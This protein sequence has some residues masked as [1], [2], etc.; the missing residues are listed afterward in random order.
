[1][2][3]RRTTSLM[4]NQRRRSRFAPT[5]ERLEPRHLLAA[6]PVISEIMASNDDNITDEDGDSSDWLKVLNAGD[7][8]IHLRGWYLTDDAADLT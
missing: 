7:T 8:D 2:R 4:K 5:L 3:Y 6:N 1:M